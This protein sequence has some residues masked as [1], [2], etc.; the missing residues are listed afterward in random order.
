MWYFPLPISSDCTVTPEQR[1]LLTLTRGVSYCTDGPHGSREPC[2]VLTKGNGGFFFAKL[3]RKEL[4][5]WH[6][7]KFPN[8]SSSYIST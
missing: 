8:N 5:T 1:S 3:N 7:S 2:M 6:I 4:K